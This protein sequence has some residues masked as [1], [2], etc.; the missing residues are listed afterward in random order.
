MNTSTSPAP[1]AAP[2]RNDDD[3]LKAIAQNRDSQAFS[4]V[5][6]RY[7][8]EA[9][10]LALH[11]TGEP[12]LAEE[13]V[14]N[15]M[16][17]I[18]RSAGTYRPGQARSWILRVVANASLKT[19]RGLRR[20]KEMTTAEVPEETLHAE[21]TPE[22]EAERTELLDALRRC[23]N[24]LPAPNR[25]MVALYY[26]A[27][28]S[29]EEIGAELEMPARTVS[30]KLEESLRKLR[31]MLGKAGFAAAAPLLAGEGLREVIC[32]GHG[33]PE[34]MRARIFDSLN[35][36]AEHSQRLAPSTGG[37]VSAAKIIA[38]TVLCTAAA[39]G[40]WFAARPAAPAPASAVTP[41]PAPLKAHWDFSKGPPADLLPFQG[42]WKWEQDKSGAGWM[43]SNQPGK[44]TPL[45]ILFPQRFAPKPILV[46]L[47]VSVDKQ[48]Y[49]GIDGLWM[50]EA[51]LHPYCYWHAP[52]KVNSEKNTLEVIALGTHTIHRVN[53]HVLSI[54]QWQ[55]PF[56]GERFG[57]I[58]T[59]WKVRSIDLRE[60]SEAEAAAY[61]VQKV[62]EALKA[63]KGSACTEVPGGPVS[64]DRI[65]EK[66]R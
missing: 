41:A 29:Q 30:Y 23:L 18:W 49:L 46:T 66:Y 1:T 52:F 40:L 60:L 65:P 38:V 9:Y 64:W 11:L 10:S 25:R 5:Y 61:D 36:V 57:M 51:Y 26:A 13:A 20:R 34:G 22:H 3:L 12:G 27:G 32:A 19:L 62:L 50:N 58:I 16:V 35:R 42:D 43:N 53:G 15:A 28:F 33:A 48:A 21:A 14:Q 55:K 56:A 59:H 54:Q 63:A 24:R 44:D 37:A 7:Q 8:H 4:Q 45:C 39:S 47:Q 17:G 6:E 2:V 31:E